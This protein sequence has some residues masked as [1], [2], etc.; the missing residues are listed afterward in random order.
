MYGYENN[1]E[2][3]QDSKSLIV[4]KG[5]STHTL[6]R[7]MPIISVNF[8]YRRSSDPVFEVPNF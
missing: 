7:L 5:H 2:S 6:E 3:T 4:M 1:F 8:T